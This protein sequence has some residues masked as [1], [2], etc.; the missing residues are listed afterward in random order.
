MCVKSCLNIDIQFSIQ[1][2]DC[3]DKNV[4]NLALSSKE[5]HIF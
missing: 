1:Y 5:L 4:K 3:A 2:Q